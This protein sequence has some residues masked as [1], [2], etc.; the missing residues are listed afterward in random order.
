MH[1]S[2][3]PI[4]LLTALAAAGAPAAADEHV[5]VKLGTL[6]PSGSPW[7]TTM[8]ELAQKWKEASGG[9]VELRIYPDGRLGNEG[10]M[11]RKMRIGQLQAAALTTVGLH[12]ITPEPQAVDAP[13]AIESYAELDYVMERIEPRLDSEVQ[14]H[15]YV[16][17]TWSDVGF[18][19]FFETKPYKTPAEMAAGK[20]FA[21]SGDPASVEAWKAGGLRPVVLSATDVMPSLQTGMIDIFAAAPLYALTARI[22]QKADKMLDLPWAIVNGAT[23]VRAETWEKI[24]EALRP[25]LLAIAREYGRRIQLEVRKMNDAA[26][27]TMKQQGLQVVHSGDLGEWRA[28]AGRANKVVRGQVVPEGVFDEVIRLRDEYR[29][30][31]VR[32]ASDGK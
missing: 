9:A 24:P 23:V 10:D 4:A 1:L 22:Y 14:K 28:A 8:K 2:I 32:K 31:G 6:A 16:V 26:V 17:L 7:H 25:K 11:V 15:G 19:H 27:E 5:V 3:R 18:V 12:E 20:V 30:G 13:M 29:K 21:W